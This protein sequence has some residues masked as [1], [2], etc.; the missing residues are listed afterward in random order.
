MTMTCDELVMGSSVLEEAGYRVVAFDARGHGRSTAPMDTAQYHYEALVEDA[1]AVMNAFR[2][3]RAV[4]VGASMGAHTAL[5]IAIDQ[6]ELVAGLVVINP[7]H[8][9]AHYPSDGL[10]EWSGL[11]LALRLSGPTAFAASL[12]FPGMDREKAVLIRELIRQRLAQHG[13]LAAVA[14]ALEAVPWAEPFDSLEELGSIRVPTLVVGS[15]DQFDRAHPYALAQAYATAIPDSEFVCE[16]AGAFP[17]AWGAREL[18]G[19][20]RDL[21]E[22]AEW[23]TRTP[24]PS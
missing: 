21:A 11:A 3:G 6:P 18:A 22:R 2:I 10:R 9:P 1:L 17:L 23:H 4:F 24:V 15:H 13:E 20:V 12:P 14:D 16:A 5:R 7:G 8:D 19:L